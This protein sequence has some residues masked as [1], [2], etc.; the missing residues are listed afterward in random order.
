MDRPI[1]AYI[2]VALC[3]FGATI[4]SP[5][6]K[7]YQAKT[8]RGVLLFVAMSTFVAACFFGVGA[9]VEGVSYEIGVLPYSI[10]CAVCYATCMLATMPALACGPLALTALIG[11]YSL[12]LPTVYGLVFVEKPLYLTQVIGFGVL[13]VSLYLVN[14]TREKKEAAEGLP[15]AVKLDASD[16]DMP[17][18]SR[19]I[20]AKWY[21]YVSL[22]FF[23]NGGVAT[24]QQAQQRAFPNLYKNTFMFVALALVTVVVLALALV[25]ERGD[26]K[27]FLR[28][29]T[30]PAA[31]CGVAN[32]ATNLIVVVMATSTVVPTFVFFPVVSAGGLLISYTISVFFFKE[33]FSALQKIGILLGLI[34]LVFLNLTLVKIWR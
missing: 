31:L 5:I 24:T 27:E 3:A 23:G 16:P 4:Q 1:V 18:R 12:I 33:R 14:M 26:L 29:G 32:G 21:L 17:E 30:V 2:L 34:S 10:V 8:S 25:R 22:I 13:L 9:L 20:P 11:S 6:K 28:F 7:W 15:D 19:K